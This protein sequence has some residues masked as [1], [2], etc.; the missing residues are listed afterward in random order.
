[1]HVCHNNDAL[2]T[3]RQKSKDNKTCETNAI[4]IQ[5]LMSRKI[6]QKKSAGIATSTL[7]MHYTVSLIQTV[8]H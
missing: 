1:M 7:S 3:N 8:V 5:K 2:M 6:R 4:R